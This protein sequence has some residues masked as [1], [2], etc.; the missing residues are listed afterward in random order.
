MWSS[1][2]PPAA[3]HEFEECLQ[4]PVDVILSLMATLNSCQE[5]LDWLRPAGQ[6]GTA[7]GKRKDPVLAPPYG[8]MAKVSRNMAGE[9]F[10]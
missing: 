8:G 2:Q 9:E 1:G 5:T 6:G 10:V 3:A 4:R 7:P